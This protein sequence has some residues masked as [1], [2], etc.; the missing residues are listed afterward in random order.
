MELLR[1]TDFVMLQDKVLSISVAAYNVS[2][3]ITQCLDSCLQ[4]ERKQQLDIIVVNDGSTDN[5]AQIVRGYE[6]RFP[7][8]I[9]LINKSNGGY[10]STVNTSIPLAEGVYYR[11]LDGDDWVDPNGLD[12]L[13][14]ALESANVDIAIAPFVER[15]ADESCIIDQVTPD[16][17]GEV[18]FENNLIPENLSM[19]SICYRTDLLQR[20][21]YELPEHRLYTDTL[22]N[23]IPLQ[24]VKSAYVTHMPVYQY[25]VG[26]VGQSISKES[27]TA[28]YE[29]FYLMVCELFFLW[30]GLENKESLSAHVLK[31]WLVGD[32]TWLLHIMCDSMTVPTQELFDLMDLLA[33]DA[34]I[35]QMCS[36][37][38]LAF[39][40]M[41]R[42]PRFMFPIF[43]K[44]YRVRH[45][46]HDN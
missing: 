38:S 43:I 4:C 3:T 41:A 10:G 13:L 31:V 36:K 37:R 27:L 40:T 46:I 12:D 14:R 21:G 26:R 2:D 17:C 30:K 6:K 5:T 15:S 16:A 28:H 22:Y 45:W 33:E 20:L 9:R 7:G 11:L 32:A 25:R 39:R 42:L 29:D 8:I 18:S 24:L 1:R 23:V 35:Y 44:A 19:H 34:E